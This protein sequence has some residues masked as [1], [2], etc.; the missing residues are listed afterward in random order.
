[1][2][3]IIKTNI[4]ESWKLQLHPGLTWPVFFNPP[5]LLVLYYALVVL[6]QQWALNPKVIYR[7]KSRA[8]TG[9]KQYVPKYNHI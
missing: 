1:M 8:K 7:L 3:A 4:T 6:L 9:Y 5:V 2:T